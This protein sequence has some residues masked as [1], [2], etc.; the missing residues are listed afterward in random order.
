[1]PD[2]KL[3]SKDEVVDF[4]K[5]SMCIIEQKDPITRYYG[6][7]VGDVFQFYRKMITGPNISWRRVI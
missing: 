7:S 5:S 1:M 2:I 6:A 4:N 3:L